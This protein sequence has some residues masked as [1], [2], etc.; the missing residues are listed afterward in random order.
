MNETSLPVSR[1][2]TPEHKHRVAPHMAIFEEDRLDQPVSSSVLSVSSGTL[3]CK[4]STPQKLE[5]LC[6]VVEMSSTSH[7]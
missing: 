6:D 2:T 5:S 7:Q 4:P 3:S 1:A